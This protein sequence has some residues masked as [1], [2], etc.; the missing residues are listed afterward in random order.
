MKKPTMVSIGTF[1]VAYIMVAA[2]ILTGLMAGF[3]THPGIV[4]GMITIA[5]AL[6]IGQRLRRAHGVAS[7]VNMALLVLV[8]LVALIMIAVG[9]DHAELWF[10]S[11][12]AIFDILSILEIIFVRSRY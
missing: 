2:V 9:N 3:S 6:I 12:Y 5:T 10:A 8:I 11:C 7:T 1:S 4:L